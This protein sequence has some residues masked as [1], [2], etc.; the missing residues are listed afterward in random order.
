MVNS[1]AP[2]S[3]SCNFELLIFKLIRDRNLDEFVVELC[4]VPPIFFMAPSERQ[5]W[6]YSVKL[7]TRF[8]YDCNFFTHP[9][10]QDGW[11]GRALRW[12]TQNLTGGLSAFFG[13]VS[14]L[15]LHLSCTNQSILCHISDQLADV[16][17]TLS[18]VSFWWIGFGE[19]IFKF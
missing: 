16:V 5:F 6:G 9:R 11:L 2:E 14:A 4:T 12:M 19:N 3:C 7:H 15:E 13:W 1:L 18:A 8:Q 10:L 17:N